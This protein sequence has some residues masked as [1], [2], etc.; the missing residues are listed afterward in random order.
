MLRGLSTVVTQA[1][2]NGVVL[3]IDEVERLVRQPR[4]ESRKA[5]LELVQN[6][7]GALEA[8]QLPHTLIAVAGTSSFFLSSRGVPM[9]EPLQQRIGDLDDG[10]FPDLDAVQI[11]LPP[12]DAARLVRVGLAVRGLYTVRYPE[13]AGRC[14]DAFL[15]RLAADGAGAFGGTVEATPRRYLRELIGVLG[16]CAQHQGY[17]PHTNYRFKVS[18][19]DPGLADAERAA[20]EGRSITEAESA[21]LPEG[22][23]L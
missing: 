14:D 7:I 5:G 19:S 11:A 6:W 20:I 12:F 8:G 17:D 4:A 2:Y 21:P 3:L 16:R 22:F 15:H 9:L 18:A 13:S 1:G 10:P 23:D